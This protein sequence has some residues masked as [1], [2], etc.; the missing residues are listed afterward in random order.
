MKPAVCVSDPDVEDHSKL[1]GRRLERRT[2]RWS[3]SANPLF[4][5]VPFLLPKA[6]LK[7]P[8]PPRPSTPLTSAL[9]PPIAP[10]DPDFQHL[11]ARCF[12]YSSFVFLLRQATPKPVDADTAPPRE[13]SPFYPQTALRGCTTSYH[14]FLTRI[15]GRETAE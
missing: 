1:R 4:R 2:A 15:Q 5:E 13:P 11:P 3:K 14:V 10:D 7:A 6:A 12:F 9:S 8:C